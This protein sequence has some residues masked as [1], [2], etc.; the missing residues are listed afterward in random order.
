MVW[1]TDERR[2]AFFPA[3]TTVR[4]NHH[5]ESP[6][7][8]EQDLNLRRTWVQAFIEWS[9]AVVITT[10]IWRHLKGRNKKIH[11]RYKNNIYLYAGNIHHNFYSWYVISEKDANNFF[12]KKFF[13]NLVKQIFL[14]NSIWFL[15]KYPSLFKTPLQ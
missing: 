14:T 7:Y 3:G 5:R 1:L 6:T 13:F 12:R 11:G 2:L 15:N 8:R 4:D 9:C 10:T